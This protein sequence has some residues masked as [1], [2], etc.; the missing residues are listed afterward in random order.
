[1]SPDRP[2]EPDEIL[3]PHEDD[4]DDASLVHADAGGEASLVEMVRQQQRDASASRAQARELIRTLGELRDAQEFLGTEL[5]RER[6]R[7]R[8]FGVLLALA[9]L[10]AAALVWAV[11]LRVD[12]VRAE[13]EAE[14]DGL[15]EVRTDEHVRALRA[16]QSETTRAL[17]Q[18]VEG[19]R[20][21]LGDTRADLA[22]S[23]RDAG[24][25]AAA[26]ERDRTAAGQREQRWIDRIA[27]LERVNGELP[28]L[29]AQVEILRDRSGAQA[30]RADGLERELRNLER[31]RAAPPVPVAVTPP[32]VGTHPARPQPAASE[33]RKAE[34]PARPAV[35]PGALRDATELGRIR[36]ILDELLLLSPGKDHFS[37]ARLGGISGRDLLELSVVGKDANGTVTRT[38]VAPR[39][40]I[41]IDVAKSTVLL[42]FLDGELV[43][44]PYR[45]PFFQG[46][47]ALLLDTDTAVWRRS[48]LTCVAYR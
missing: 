40:R 21:Q 31:E 8:W 41:S 27:E 19:A 3:P 46:R 5:R 29:R 48:G 18:R 39:A 34:K 7:G 26:R 28:G 38:I 13:Q 42:E 15:R 1:M 11:W 47:Y 12:S 20:E 9:P 45:A 14:I 37:V 25:S 24:E 32:I 44:G 17:E 43:R 4:A 2:V 10:A 36:K 35:E 33:P 6:R 16:A 30:A 22:A 23:R